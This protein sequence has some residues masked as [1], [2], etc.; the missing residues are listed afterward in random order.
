M[1]REPRV[2]DALI[3]AANDPDSQVREKVILALA[4]SRDDRAAATIAR[5]TKDPDAQVREK[6]VLGL[7]LLGRNN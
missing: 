6:A 4:F 7:S 3:E 5:A 1:R 2:V